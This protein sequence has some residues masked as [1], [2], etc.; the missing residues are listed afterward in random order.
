MLEL[1][2]IRHGQPDYTP[3]EERGFIGHGKDLAPLTAKGVAQAK[4][5]AKSPLLQGSRLI[6]SSPYTH[7]LQTAS[8]VAMKTGLDIVVEVDLREW[9]PD[10]T[11]QFS[12]PEEACIAADE[13]MLRNGVCAW[14]REPLWENAADMFKR[15]LNCL[16]PYAAKYDKIIVVGHSMVMQQFLPYERIRFGSVWQVFLPEEM[17]CKK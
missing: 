16:R 17:P 12:T 14:N 11:Y 5:A 6:V 10:L 9:T 2:M 8:Y 3:C 15:A 4:E 7:A 1:I 13:Y